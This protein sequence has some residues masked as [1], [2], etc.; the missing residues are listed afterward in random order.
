MSKNIFMK[1][2]L[3]QP[4]RTGLLVLLI[5]LASF[6]FF[7]RTVE[8]V[9]VRSEI[10]RLGRQYHSLGTVGT[11]NIWDDVSEAAAILEASPYIAYVDRRFGVEGILVDMYSPD[12]AGMWAGLDNEYQTR[13]TEALFIG[14]VADIPPIETNEWGVSWQTVSVHVNYV[15][16]G[17]PEH[18]EPFRLA[19]LVYII[20]DTNEDIFSP[21][22]MGERFLF[23]GAFYL[24]AN[25]WGT[26]A[27]PRPRSVYWMR[28]RPVSGDTLFIPEASLPE[29]LDFA[30]DYELAHLAT[31][32]AFFEN[33]HRAVS[34]QPVRDM[35]VLPIVQPEAPIRL[36]LGPGVGVSGMAYRIQYGRFINYD[37]YLN[38]NPVAV[39]SVGMAAVRGLRIGDTIQVSIPREQ[40]VIR[41]IPGGILVRSTPEEY[42]S[43]IIELEIVGIYFDF[44]RTRIMG[45][46]FP[47]TNIYFPASLLPEGRNP[48]SPPAGAI[49]GWYHPQHL[50]SIWFSYELADSRQEQSFIQT[51]GPIMEE[52]GFSL[53]HF[54]AR[55]HEFWAAVDP[56]L[57]VLTFNA[58]VFWVVLVLVIALVVFLYLGQR[59]KDIA[60]QRALGTSSPW[61]L[62]RIIA[63][64]LVFGTPAILVGG[65]IG[66][67]YALRVA[68]YT[69][70]HLEYIVPDF[71]PAIALS[72][73]WFVGMSLIIFFLLLTMIIVGMVKIIRNPVLAQLQGVKS[74]KMRTTPPTISY[75]DTGSLVLPVPEGFTLPQTK[76]S[77]SSP[78]RLESGLR[79]IFR[80]IT[81]SPAKSVLGILIALFFV[82]VLGWLSESIN[83]SA[84]LI[85]YLYENTIVEGNIIQDDPFHSHP[86]RHLGDIIYKHTI[87][88]IRDSGFVENLYIEGGHWRSFIVPPDNQGSFPTNWYDIIGY[89]RAVSMEQ[90]VDV[91]DFMFTFNDFDLFLAENYIEDVGGFQTD[92]AEGF[93]P[94]DFIYEDGVAYIII[95][96]SI[97]KRRGVGLGDM[98]Y[99]GYTLVIPSFMRNIPAQIIGIHNGHI[100]R[101]NAS[102]AIL[103]PLDAFEEHLRA[104][105]LYTTLTFTVDPA[106]NR[107]IARVH[108]YI[109]DIVLS[110]ISGV[111]YL[112]LVFLD[113]M[114]YSMVGV[115]NQTL[116]LLELVYPVVMVALITIAA[117]LSMLL[118]LQTAKNAAILHVLGATKGKTMVLLLGEQ[119]LVCLAGML[120]GMVF[121]AIL[122]VVFGGTLL[123]SLGLYFAAVLAGALVGGIIV[124]RRKPLELL[125]VRE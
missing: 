101:E 10:T 64:A 6:A 113:Q 23:R 75:R 67:I 15:L 13:I 79:F 41:D 40:H 107:E 56:M 48:A 70:A 93:G 66:W 85:D 96:E 103:I 95:A 46:T 112:R 22:M 57:L 91:M 83:R 43:H 87:D 54:E 109:S 62:W 81:R 33:H 73:I 61:L 60:I 34:L 98:V 123:I 49:P 12:I 52:L 125:Q 121:L 99:V 94:S 25:P 90:N 36:D 117:G 77:R 38:S 8:F 115:A 4:V 65:A 11:E 53:I 80:H 5:G 63:S 42:H 86:D 59:R 28:I 114:L 88:G 106:Y 35:T 102:D 84:Q 124:I 14:T 1:S 116:L 29:N 45:N 92:F 16:A 7:L 30:S 68:D 105:G 58:S 31:E 120:P 119:I 72:P 108:E 50:P 19:N 32:I 97:A 122:G 55:A 26:F 69:L 3:R 51:Y 39:I 111:L 24:S 82:L 9:T 89:D 71:Q 37:D 74:K 100:A 20:Q 27:L 17:M 76:L 18:I 47:F 21:L 2:M 78:A 118:L 104:M 44:Y 110:R